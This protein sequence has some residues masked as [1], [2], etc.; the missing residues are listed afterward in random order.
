MFIYGALRPIGRLLQSVLTFLDAT[1]HPLGFA[2]RIRTN[3]QEVIDAAG[4]E[5]SM[6][7]PAFPDPA[8]IL[9]IRVHNPSPDRPAAPVFDARKHEFYVTSRPNWNYAAGNTRAGAASAHLTFGAVEDAA[10]FQYHFL[11]ALAFQLI[12]SRHLTPIHAACIARRGEATLLAGNSH[13]G[14]SSL[15]YA[16]ARRGWTFISDDS[17]PLLR[18]SAADR[19]VLGTPHSLRLRPDAPALFPELAAFQPTLRGNGKQVLQIPTSVLPI[20]TALTAHASRFILL[21]RRD[22]PAHLSSIGRDNV[23]GHC[24]QHFYHWDLPI[25]AAQLAAFDTMLDGIELLSL[26]Y[27]NLDE[28]IDLLENFQEQ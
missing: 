16:L 8:L 24:A 18:R 14:K 7:Q 26:K 20:Q 4:A 11:D 13:A 23:V 6:W 28:A 3:A 2:V 9:I 12:T 25:A 19:L 15:A 27:S 22:G 10:W 1:F 21:D 17:C 5:W